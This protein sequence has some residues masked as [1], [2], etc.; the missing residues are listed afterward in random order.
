MFT[1]LPGTGHRLTFSLS[2][3][4]TA[5]RS[6]HPPAAV[7]DAWPAYR[8]GLPIYALLFG[9]SV[10]DCRGRTEP[11]CA[12]FCASLLPPVSVGVR[13]PAPDVGSHP[14]SGPI[15]AA[16]M[17]LPAL[18]PRRDGSTHPQSSSLEC[19]GSPNLSSPRALVPVL[20]VLP[21]GKQWQSMCQK[22][23]FKIC[24]C[25]LEY[26][27]HQTPRGH[28]LCAPWPGRRSSRRPPSKLASS[29]S[30]TLTESMRGVNG[31]CSKG[32]VG[33]NSPCC[34]TE[35]PA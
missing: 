11:Y 17:Q 3:A 12:S 35:S 28:F 32:M 13:S 31:F 4:A 21:N 7:S 34:A 25:E 16:R 33:S 29:T 6:A 23:T 20:R 19:H 24:L 15:A 1:V 18:T 14:T 8:I 9:D 30:L 22:V 10:S 2:R 26:A 27:V 5:R